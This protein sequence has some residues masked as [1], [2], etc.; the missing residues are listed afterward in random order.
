MKT[1]LGVLLLAGTVLAGEKAPPHGHGETDLVSVSATFIS[2]DDI[3][4][5]FGTI[6]NGSF[7]V[8]EVK[9]TPR[10]DKP[11]EVQLDDFILRSQSDGDHSG[12][13]V[14]AQIV[15]GAALVVKQTF[16]PRTNPGASP[17]IAGTKVEM[18]NDLSKGNSGSPEV[19]AALKKRIL[20]EGPT[21][22]A[23]TGL[24]F[25][26]MEK[27]KPRNLVLSYTAPD[28]KLRIQFK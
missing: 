4:Q 24:L 1:I 18:K 22:D 14:A 6:F 12:P 2:Q 28:G 16:A 23:V 17:M 26:P 19:L 5:E 3:K 10:G 25:F 7:T 20:P 11:V 21:Q 13:L 27:E 9:L 15:D 8:I